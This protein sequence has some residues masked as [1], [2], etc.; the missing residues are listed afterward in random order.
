[1][2]ASE[3]NTQLHENSYQLIQEQ[4]S[5]KF[6]SQPENVEF[7]ECF[8][9]PEITSR[10]LSRLLYIYRHICRQKFANDASQLPERD[11]NW[12]IVGKCKTSEILSLGSPPFDYVEIKQSLLQI[13][14][15]KD[16]T[17]KFVSESLERKYQIKF[18]SLQQLRA[19]YALI[20][21]DVILRRAVSTVPPSLL[22]TYQLAVPT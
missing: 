21:G 22:L 19:F 12:Y 2:K 9:V 4:I 17:I 3:G 10:T 8:F 16:T 11:K 7:G 15:L 6:Y 1:M 13:V 18:Q 20:Y 5:T 14:Y